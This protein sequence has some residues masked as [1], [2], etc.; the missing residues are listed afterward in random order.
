[1]KPTPKPD[2][3]PLLVFGAHPDDIEFGCGG[4]IAAETQAG[5]RAHFVV[6][7]RGES[8]THGTPAQRTAEAKAAAK[9]LG[10]SI[11][12]IDLGGDA[13][14]EQRAAY[15]VKIAAIIRRRRPDLVLAP[16]VVENQHPDH[17]VLGKLVRDAARLARYGGVKELKRWP[18]HAVQQV[19]FYALTS[20]AEPRDVTPVFVDVSASKV[21]TAWEAAMRAHESQ[22]ATRSYA[23][24][25]L[26]RAEVNGQRCGVRLAIPVF[27]SSPL[28]LGRLA[29]IGRGARQF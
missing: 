18:A 25:N 1:M 20:D 4:I 11:E 5:Q 10:A 2:S 23:E 8:G 17:A 7:S 27:P 6:C 26:A 13:H 29:G 3:V 21:A 16:T 22:A 24:F 28:V 15:A 9:L 14:F 19:V 12:F